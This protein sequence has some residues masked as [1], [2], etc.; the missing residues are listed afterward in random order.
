MAFFIKRSHPAFGTDVPCM[1]SLQ[2]LEYSC[3][4]VNLPVNFAAVIDIIESRFVFLYF[5]LNF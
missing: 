2:A 1:F 5:N 3:R 4:A